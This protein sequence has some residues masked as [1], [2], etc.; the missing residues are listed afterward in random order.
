ML[1]LKLSSIYEK[2]KIKKEKII[3]CILMFIL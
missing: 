3:I 1:Y 2:E